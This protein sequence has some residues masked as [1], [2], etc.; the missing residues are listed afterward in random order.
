MQILDLCVGKPY[1]DKTSGQ[2]KKRW[3]KVGAMFINHDDAGNPRYSMKFDAYPTGD[4][5]ISAFE[6]KENN[7]Q[8]N[9]Q[10]AANTVTAPEPARPAAPAREE[11]EVRLEDVTF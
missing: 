11:E 8:G 2:E 9:G 5:F 3:V 10:P 6:K 7:G 4:V 1:Q